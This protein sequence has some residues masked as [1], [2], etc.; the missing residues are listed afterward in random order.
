MIGGIGR[1]RVCL[2][3][4]LAGGMGWDRGGGKVEVPRDEGGGLGF[5]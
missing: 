1:G 5:F 3:S 4:G 2:G